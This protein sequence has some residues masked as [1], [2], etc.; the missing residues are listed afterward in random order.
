M[1]SKFHHPFQEQ[2]YTMFHLPNIFK[3]E[4]KKTLNPISFGD[5]DVDNCEIATAV[6]RNAFSITFPS[7]A[8]K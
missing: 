1:V 8:D 6:N 3:V 2:I 4:S 7:F 5:S